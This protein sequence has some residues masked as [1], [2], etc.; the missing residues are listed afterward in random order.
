M[1]VGSAVRHLGLD[2]RLLWH[3]FRGGI[4]LSVM[5]A[6]MLYG[7]DQMAGSL[8]AAFRLLV[9]AACGAVGLFCALRLMPGIIGPDLAKLL[10]D[11]IGRLPVGVASHFAFLGQPR[12]M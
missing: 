8:H 2:A 11:I 12:A 9:D 4:L 10:G 1:I 5:L 6:I 7:I 3:A